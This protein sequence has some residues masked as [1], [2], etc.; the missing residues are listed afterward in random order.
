MVVIT[1]GFSETGEEGKKREA[2]VLEKVRSSGMRMVGPNCLGIVNTDP[3]VRLNATFSPIYPPEG[4][5]AL[6]SQSG[7][8][9]LALLDYAT[10][11]NLGISTFVSV[12][13]RADISG[14]D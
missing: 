9:G 8:L 14:N 7:A 1:A 2:A 6:S 13:N 12:G 5:V 4:R 10:R 11:L 3:N